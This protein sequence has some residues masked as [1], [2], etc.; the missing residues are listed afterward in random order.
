LR[1]GKPANLQIATDLN[2]MLSGTFKGHVP[3][4]ITEWGT[5]PMYDCPL[6]RVEATDLAMP[7]LVNNEP[8]ELPVLHARCAL[9]NNDDNDYYVLDQLSNPIFLYTRLGK[10]GD[11]SQTIKITFE[12]ANKTNSLEQKLADKQPVEI[13]GIYFD[14]NSAHIKPESE[15]VL[16]QISDVMHKNPTWKL[17]VSGHTDNIGDADFNQKLSQ[18]RAEAVKTALVKEY[19]IAPDRLTTSG[20]GASRPVA[21]NKKPE[22][23]AL[24][25]R[26]ELQRQ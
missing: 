9:D 4:T 3:P 24:N 12:T 1:T 7:V 13:Y 6:Q 21:D 18:A 20:Y 25:R 26:V 5:I 8:T 22:G 10:Y 19:K 17:S 2:T 15:A 23:R 14:F 11:S 16:K